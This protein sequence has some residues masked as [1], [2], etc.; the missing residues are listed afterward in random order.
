M[1]IDRKLDLVFERT[2]D[3]RPSLVWIAWTQP[4]PLV[5]PMNSAGL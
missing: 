5:A 1:I 3:V 2:I 4:E